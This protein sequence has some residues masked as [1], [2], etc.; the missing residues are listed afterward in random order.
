M[1]T[2]KPYEQLELPLV[3]GPPSLDVLPLLERIKAK[4][5]E[6]F[7]FVESCVAL[8]LIGSHSHGTY[9]PNTDPGGIDDIDLMAIVIP[10]KHRTYGLRRF[11]HKVIKEGDLDC[12]VYA[13]DKYVSLLLKSNPNVLGTLWLED[14]CYLRRTAPFINLMLNRGLFLTKNIY[15]PF[16]GYARAQLYKMTHNAHEGYMGEKRKKLVEKYGYDVKNAAHLIRLLRMGIEALR[17]GTIKV[18]R[19]D[20]HELISIKKGGWTLEKVQENARLGFEDAEVAKLNSWLRED[21]ETEHI[22]ELLL[23]GYAMHWHSLPRSEFNEW[24]S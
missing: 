15:A 17:T 21:P 24:D 13:W 9:I 22:E 12:V 7:C 1:R 19:P 11:Q 16:M 5:D 8:L 23:E 2:S 6:D 10:P 4:W 14:F 20:A 18:Y 3:I